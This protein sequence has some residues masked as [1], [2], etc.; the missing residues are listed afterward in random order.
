MRKRYLA[1]LV[2]TSTIL[3]LP[4]AAQPKRKAVTKPGKATTVAAPAPKPV[5]ADAPIIML[6]KAMVPSSEFAYVYKKNNEKASD[7]YT[8][9]SVREYLELYANFKLKVMDAQRLGEDTL[10]SYVKELETYRKQLAQPYLTEKSV[11]DKLIKEAFARQNEEVNASH[12]LITCGPDADRQDT[13]KAYNKAMDLR[14]RVLAGESFEA[15]AK[16]NSND[17]SAKENNGKLGYFTSL[18]MVYPFEDAAYKLG[19]GKVSM[20]VR[21]RFGYHLIKVNDRRTSRGQVKVAHIMIQ[22]RE[23]M[24]ETESQEAAKKINEIHDRLV[25]GEDWKTLCSQFSDDAN[26]KEKGGELPPFGTGQ[27]IPEFEDVAFAMSK[28]NEFSKP[29]QTSFGWHVVKFIERIKA[30]SYEEAEPDLKQRVS[31]DSRSELNQTV[32]LAKIRKENNLVEFPAILKLAQTKADTNLVN[33]N[34]KADKADKDLAAKALF[35]IQDQN[36]NVGQF[37]SYVAGA[38]SKKESNDPAFVLEQYYKNFVNKSL[39]EYEE[40]HLEGKHEDYRMLLKEYKE[41]ILLFA[42]MDKKVWSKALEDTAGLRAYFNANRSKY[43]WTKRA[44]AV[45]YNAENQKVLDEVKTKLAGKYFSVSE[46]KQEAMMF[47]KNAVAP[48]K[49]SANRLQLVVDMLKRDPSLKVEIVGQIDAKEKSGLGRKRA[50]AVMDSLIRR[51][52]NGEQLVAV[53]AA[54][55]LST[56]TKPEDNQKVTFRVLGSSPKALERVMNANGPLTLK[57]TEGMFQ[58]GDNADVDKTKWT[59]GDYQIEDKGRISWV[60]VLAIEAP[61]AKTLDEARGPA[62]SDYQNYLEKEWVDSLRKASP[63]TY[64]EEEVKKLVKK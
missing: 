40:A 38:Q 56:A 5:L 3:T 7:A 18:Q 37:F 47:D 23:G 63:V 28:P 43:Q 1:L 8:E 54:K 50:M 15:L 10:T 60:R 39:L 4:L 29:F 44:K 35:R 13:L 2:A 46:P 52:A 11:T 33:G 14:K 51:G 58:Q 41:G 55:T 30:K 57:V 45:V 16:A 53:D 61:R 42:L 31:R 27:L 59:A 36:Y 6:G 22:S 26:S 34:F 32:F 21:T 49:T 62:V 9:K 12:I 25:K 17:P 64:N 48:V 19:I 20:P 24:T